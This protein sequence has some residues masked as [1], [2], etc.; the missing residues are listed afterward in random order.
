VPKIC[1]FT[2]QTHDYQHKLWAHALAFYGSFKLAFGLKTSN[3]R[4]D[5]PKLARTPVLNVSANIQKLHN[6]TCDD[7]TKLD[8]NLA[9][10]HM[11]LA[12]MG[13]DF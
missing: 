2:M 7:I 10:A 12:P 1:G 6:V 11:R 9:H 5:V 8:D 3:R 13:V 4:P